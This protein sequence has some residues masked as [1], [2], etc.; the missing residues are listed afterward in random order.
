MVF[1]YK[2][3]HKNI[4]SP[5]IMDACMNHASTLTISILNIASC[6]LAQLKTVPYNVHVHVKKL[7][8]YWGEPLRSGNVKNED[9]MLHIEVLHQVF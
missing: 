8:T 5:F 6:E 7:A 1:S 4:T 2:H 9:P 3:I